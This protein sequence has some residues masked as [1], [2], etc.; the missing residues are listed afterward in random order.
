M[1]VNAAMTVFWLRMVP[2]VSVLKAQ[3]LSQMEKRVVVSLF[4]FC[5]FENTHFQSDTYNLHLIGKEK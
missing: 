1:Q 5:L 2:Y 4:T 3:C